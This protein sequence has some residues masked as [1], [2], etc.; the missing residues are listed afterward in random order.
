MPRSARL[1]TAGRRWFTSL[2]CGSATV[3]ASPSSAAGGAAPPTAPPR[4]CVH[5]TRG[6][7]D[8]A[9]PA[10]AASPGKSGSPAAARSPLDAH[11]SATAPL[12]QVPPRPRWWSVAASTR[13]Q[14]LQF[15]PQRV[16]LMPLSKSTGAA[17]PKRRQ[18]QAPAHH[19]HHR[20][21]QPVAPPDALI[22]LSFRLRSPPLDAHRHDDE[23]KETFSRTAAA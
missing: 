10:S 19:A 15:L 16:L 8:R 20:D 5:R 18:E 6:N 2:W 23:H 3:A 9:P 22:D 4:S 21:P 11:A 17:M 1:V 12:V 13:S 7:G 14:P